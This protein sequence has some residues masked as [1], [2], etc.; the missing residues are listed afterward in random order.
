[1][2]EWARRSRGSVV[3]FMAMHPGWADTPG[4]AESLPAFHRVM[5][6]LLRSAAEGA[7]T[8]IWLAALPDPT[9]WDG[10]LLLDRRARPFDRIPSTRL[11]RTERSE[12]WD[13]VV[14]L[15]GG[16]PPGGPTT[17]SGADRA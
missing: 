17:L 5:R 2:R 10:Q 4:L 9:P 14:D 12:L 11:S 16:P 6:P 15:C 8:I 1:M 7:D 13:S 3:T